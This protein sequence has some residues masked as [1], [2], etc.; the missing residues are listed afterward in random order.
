MRNLEAKNLINGD[1][2]KAGA[3]SPSENQTTSGAIAAAAAAAS[4]SINSGSDHA[5]NMPAHSQEGESL[6]DCMAKVKQPELVLPSGYSPTCAG[7]EEGTLLLYFIPTMQDFKSITPRTGM[8]RV[9]A[10]KP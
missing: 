2:I 6:D 9:N 4:K 5:S 3:L 8:G 10:S 1:D 7:F